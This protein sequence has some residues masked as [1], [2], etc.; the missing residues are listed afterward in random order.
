MR[1]SRY[2]ISQIRKEFGTWNNYVI[3]AGDSPRYYIQPSE[4][5]LL[6]N[7]YDVKKKL[8][9]VPYLSE[10]KIPLSKYSYVAYLKRYGNWNS[11]LASVG[12]T[13]LR[14]SAGGLTKDMIISDYYK[15]KKEKFGESKGRSLLHREFGKHYSHNKI[16]K[17]FG[18][19]RNLVLELEGTTRIILNC[20]MCGQANIECDISDKKRFCNVCKAIKSAES[21]LKYHK[22]MSKERRLY[23]K[24]YAQKYREEHREEVNKRNRTLWYKDKEYREKICGRQLAYYKEH[25]EEINEKARK[26]WKEH[27]DK[28]NEQHKRARRH[29]LIQPI[30]PYSN[31]IR[32]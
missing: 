11:F 7:Y 16:K 6:V 24:E 2:S 19:Y 26:Y 18:S 22:N 28:M 23:L 1:L 17:L 15:I 5:E 20:Q 8:G 32:H 27:K 9:R 21:V 12:D 29:R 10:M 14:K 13:A 4:N 25:R 30:T 31:Q 3:A